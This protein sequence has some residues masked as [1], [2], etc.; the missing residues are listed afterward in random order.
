MA[1]EE[2]KVAAYRMEDKN[3]TRLDNDR[4]EVVGDQ[5]VI[6]APLTIYLNGSELVTLLCTPEKIDCLA[7]GFLRSEGFVTALNDLQALRARPEEGLVEVELKDQKGLEEKLFGKRTI[8]SGC[9]K[10]TIFYNVLDSLRSA[11]LTGTLKISAAR[12]WELNS[13]LQKK[14]LLFKATGGVHSAALADSEKLIYFHEDIGRHNAV[15]KIIG[16]C[17]LKGTDTGDKALFTSGR[18]SSEILLKAAKLKIQLI[19]SRSAPTT[20]SVDLAEAL[21]ITLVGFVRGRRMNIYSHPW[22]IL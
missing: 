4:R 22:R 21:N 13:E 3:I 17:L 9:G 19:V 8:T 12:V 20:L 2:E 18:L 15:D 16:E 1:P 10:G 5:V 14:A 6:E 7:L 11:P